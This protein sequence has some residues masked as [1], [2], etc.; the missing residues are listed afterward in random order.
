ML[1][2]RFPRKYIRVMQFGQMKG[3]V[4]QVRSICSVRTKIGNIRDAGRREREG[5][6]KRN[7]MTL[8][9]QTQG[10]GVVINKLFREI[11][12]TRRE[13][14]TE[15]DVNRKFLEKQLGTSTVASKPASLRAARLYEDHHRSAEQVRPTKGKFPA[16]RKNEKH[17]SFLRPVSSISPT[18]SVE[19]YVSPELDKRQEAPRKK[20]RK[21][22]TTKQANVIPRVPVASGFSKRPLCCSREDDSHGEE[23]TRGGEPERSQTLAE[24][25][26]SCKR[27]NKRPWEILSR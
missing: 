25:S 11:G 4:R 13:A 23:T 16:P 2:T 22:G 19:V 8:Y 20:S 10:D 1:F 27:V 12:F 9:F 6:R 17:L 5:G 14:P 21:N 18:P 7:L 24:T 3:A 26:S 15:E